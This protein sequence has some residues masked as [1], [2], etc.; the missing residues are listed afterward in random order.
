MINRLS[1]ALTKYPKSWK[2]S[3]LASHYWRLKGKAKEAIDCLC[4][5]YAFAPIDMKDI[6]LVGLSNIFALLHQWADALLVAKQAV[7]LAPKMFM[8]YFTIANIYSA[9]VIK[10]KFFKLFTNTLC[11][12]IFSQLL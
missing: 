10:Y 9:K 2:L 11:M 1:K 3:L 5:S 7:E 6:A 12:F 4:L 8:H